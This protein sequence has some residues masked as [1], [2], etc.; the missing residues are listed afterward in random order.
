MKLAARIL[1]AV[2]IFMLIMGTLPAFAQPPTPYVWTVVII[3]VLVIA[4]LWKLYRILA[5]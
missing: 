4:G 2:V 3:K 5:R 1:I